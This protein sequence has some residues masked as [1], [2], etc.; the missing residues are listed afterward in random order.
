[1]K[2]YYILKLVT[3]ILLS[4]IAIKVKAESPK[5]LKFIKAKSI[6]YRNQ[7][8]IFAEQEVSMLID[9]YTINTDSLIYNVYDDA[10]SC[11][12]KVSIS[13]NQ[14]NIMLGRNLNARDKL[15]VGTVS[16]IIF[17]NK[18]VIIAAKAAEKTNK[19]QTILYR[20]RLTPCKIYGNCSPIWQ[21]SCKE[22]LIDVLNKKIVYK[23]LFFEI[24]GIPV[25]FFPYFS[26]PILNAKAQS[27]ILV[28]ELKGNKFSI[29]VYL[30]IKPNLDFTF[31]PRI[32]KKTSLFETEIRN[33]VL[34]GE[35]KIQSSYGYVP[36][37][38]KK[39]ESTIQNYKK[40]GFYINSYGNFVNESF[41]Y[42]FYISKASDIAYLKNYYNRY[43][44]Y[45]SSRLYFDNITNYNYW[46]MEGLYFQDLRLEDLQYPGPS[47][48]LPRVR[49]KKIINL[50]KFDNTF[51]VL[52]NTMLI[53]NYYNLEAL[54][55]FTQA[56]IVKHL[57][58]SKGSLIRVKILSNI[59]LS[60]INYLEREKEGIF[61]NNT[62]GLQISLNHPLVSSLKKINIV[63][64]PIVSL[65]LNDNAKSHSIRV[66]NNDSCKDIIFVNTYDKTNYSWI[67]KMFSQGVNF[68]INS[69]RKYF[70]LFLGQ[71]IHESVK[72][73]GYK[74]DY[75]SQLQ[76]NIN[77]FSNM[78]YNFRRDKHFRHIK[79]EVGVNIA[80]KKL[81]LMISAIKM[82]NIREF[83][84]NEKLERNKG[85]VKQINVD[86]SY[87]IDYNLLVANELR[88]D[89][90]SRSKAQVFYK[91]VRMTY[92]Y[93]CVSFT[94]KFSSDYMIDGSRGIK[95]VNS[96]TISL[97]L[98][99]LNM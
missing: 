71:Y 87:L 39:D 88:L 92:F 22:S 6:E 69:E 16:D 81:N 47:L 78:F 60:T 24:Y 42:G 3:L 80:D 57:L 19:N 52:E 64:D 27:G 4:I 26:H 12:G 46:V 67:R 49:I 33:K 82:R 10:L 1:M 5:N 95:K 63:L 8:K 59:D 2:A 37:R 86:L 13:D 51:L 61:I 68:K 32:S 94:T 98:K 55:I 11:V 73:P 20:A 7:N 28:P 18:D 31:T 23:N 76:V 30:L 75:L 89:I 25:F 91:S 45:L 17:K 99:V 56:S 41:K 97:G 65:M 70:N 29:P 21:V 38:I 36:Y 66:Y 79:D 62:P 74:Q 35:Y 85:F 93:D 14:G 54:N 58:T 77:D 50:E 48:I 9:K 44:S 84:F 43:D 96:N 53:H 34:K 83:Y 90:S 15:E 72:K 40:H